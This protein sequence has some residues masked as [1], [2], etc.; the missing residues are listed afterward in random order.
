VFA[1]VFLAQI[2]EAAG[3]LGPAMMH[4]ERTIA[5]DPGQVSIWH[6]LAAH[7]RRAGRLDHLNELDKRYFERFR[8]QL[9]DK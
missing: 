4:M 6:A 5:L 2:D 9:P 3:R 1:H 8:R 7:Y